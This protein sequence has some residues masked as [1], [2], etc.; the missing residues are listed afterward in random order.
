MTN[1]AAEDT[2]DDAVS[3]HHEGGR[4]NPLHHHHHRERSRRFRWLRRLRRRV[5][6][7]NLGLQIALVVVVA[8]V[9]IGVITLVLATDAT[10]RVQSSF[11]SLQRLLNSITDRPE[12]ELTLDDINRLR[13]SLQDVNSTLATVGGRARLVKPILSLNR[14]LSALLSILDAGQDL[15]RAADSML[16][17]LQPT[18]FFLV[19]GDDSSTLTAQISSGERIV[20]LLRIGRPR[21]VSAQNDLDDAGA[22]IAKVRT[23]GLSTQTLMLLEQIQ[24]YQQELIG[25][26]SILMSAPDLLQV[27][28]GLDSEQSYLILSQNNDEL[29]PSG[30]YISTYGWLV[31]RNGQI[32]NYGYNPSTATSPN[33]PPS[34][35]GDGVDIP[36]WWLR[37]EEPIYAAWDGS[38]TPDFPETAQRAM[39]FYNNG[40]NPQSPVGGVIALD[41]TAFEYILEA[42]GQVRVPNYDLVVTKDNFRQVIY[43]LRSSGEG[44]TPHK[45]FLAALYKQIF[46]DWQ[47]MG[48]DPARSASMLNA[49]L[50]AL[51]E[52]HLMLYFADERLDNALNLLNWSG[53]QVDAVSTDY[54]MVVDTNLGNKSNHSVQRNEISDI[55]INADHSVLTHL[56]ISYDYPESVASL[57][58]AVN[59]DYHGPVT[60]NNLLQVYVPANSLFVESKGALYQLRQHAN[61]TDVLYTALVTV[62]YNSSERFELTY[63]S[64]EIVQ[65]VGDYQRYHLLIQK[66]PGMHSEN[67][68]LQISLPPGA[69]LV[70]AN[71]PAVANY[72]ID[73][74]ILEFQLELVS[75][76]EIEILFQQP[77]TQP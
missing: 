32:I 63:S 11:V 2:R 47:A 71:P 41:V 66:Q 70:S 22:S 75:D 13:S 35:Q 77:S 16:E 69:S 52:K 24:R 67:V 65:A 45:Q 72:N 74:E 9:V 55:E 1:G 62:P 28:L 46:A 8:A 39:W 29:R 48:S 43:D 6:L 10:T 33:P 59:A 42:L 21:F 15:S 44:N 25:I 58:P 34:S 61:P 26:Q 49:L 7:R 53:R 40:N 76:T 14:D 20:D 38:W 56:T 5:N 30:G 51:R 3:S 64:P 37:Y 4:P 68:N 50:Q 73:R 23:E 18:L 12:T 36:N 31:V 17:G 60:Y 54:L 27:A 57:D 19:G